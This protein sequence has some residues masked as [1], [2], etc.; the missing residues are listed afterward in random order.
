MFEYNCHPSAQPWYYSLE[1][2]SSACPLDVPPHICFSK[3]HFLFLFL[4]GVHLV[5]TPF[6][7]YLD[8]N[9][10]GIYCLLSYISHSIVPVNVSSHP[11]IP[12]LGHA[13]RPFAGQ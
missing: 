2:E 3:I 9:S 4:F 6:K 10:T 8:S 11:K 5:S 7:P 12:N 1:L 13:A